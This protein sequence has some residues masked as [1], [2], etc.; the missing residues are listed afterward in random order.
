[1]IRRPPRSTLTDTLFPYPTLF[2]SHLE[3][4]RYDRRVIDGLIVPSASMR[5]ISM[6]LSAMSLDERR[7]LPCIGHERAGLDVAGCAIL[8]RILDIW[9]A[10]RLAVADRG[11]RE[12]ILRGLMVRDRIVLCWRSEERRVGE[13]CVSTC[14]SWG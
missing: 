14:N 9:P 3:L 1:M 10:E 6:R 12:G 11:I 2:R 13:G 8:E 5:D 4:P 7:E